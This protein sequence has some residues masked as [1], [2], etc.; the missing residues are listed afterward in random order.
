MARRNPNGEGTI[1][2][3][4]DGRYEGAAYFLTVSGQRKRLR[5]Y[6][7]TRAEAHEKLTQAKASAQRG[8]PLPDRNWKLGEYLDY[9]LENVV[10]PNRRP[11]TYEAYKLRVR[12]NLQPALG[13]YSLTHLN[14]ATV[15]RFIN[16]QLADGHSV[17]KVHIMREVLSS[18][19]SR[20][21]REELVLR[22][23]ARLVDL[24]TYERQE[25][26][27]W[28]QDEARQFLQAARP[29]PLYTAFVL[30]VV[31]GLRLGE[32]LGLRWCDVDISNS[33]L[34]IRQQLQRT[35]GALRQGPVKTRAG[36]RDLTLVSLTRSVIEHQ[37]ARQETACR[38]AGSAWRGTS[39]LNELI[40]TT[41]SG[42]PIEPRN[43]VR[44]FHRIN[45]QHGIRDIKVHHVRH[46]NATF[47]KML[48]VSA[49][50]AQLIL[51][52][53]QISTTQEIYQHGDL[54]SRSAALEKV[55][56]LFMRTTGGRITVSNSRQIMNLQGWSTLSVL[57]PTEGFEPTTRCLQRALGDG[58]R[59]RMTEVNRT[60][61][62]RRRQWMLGVVAVAS[63][64]HIDSSTSAS[65]LNNDSSPCI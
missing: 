59:Y 57:E 52:H 54:E 5:V 3:R 34:R 44:S 11:R 26:L 25:I 49:R 13:S 24:P 4:K 46:T 2:R 47:L 9:W 60:V 41:R 63:S 19:L 27:P 48:G 39:D 40:F 1:Y 21:Q 45:Q 50:D 64:R 55:E 18:A 35:G 36:R 16:Q 28:S 43:F 10:L 30:L 12:L 42:L 8:I 51:G 38:A 61:N 7:R 6:G 15:Q 14:V 17:R 58:I 22:N 23:V 37:R 32:V 56:R 65:P 29:D 20:A 53:S 31:Y 33:T 62:T